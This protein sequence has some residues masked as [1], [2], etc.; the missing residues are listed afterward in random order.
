M[1]RPSYELIGD[2]MTRIGGKN[3]AYRLRINLS[4]LYKWAARPD[5]AEEAFGSDNARNNPIDRVQDLIRT[6]VVGG[7]HDLAVETMNCIA[8]EFGGAFISGNTVAAIKRVAEV[9]GSLNK[10]SES[11]L[12]ALSKSP[13]VPG[14]S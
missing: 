8:R 11:D 6:A 2:L 9:A 13:I 7:H 10:V 14:R 4:L 5:Q 12:A 3:L 1:D